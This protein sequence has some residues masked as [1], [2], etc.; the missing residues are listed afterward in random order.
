MPSKLS[1]IIPALNEEK[2]LPLL[3]KCL[4]RERFLIKE[5]IVADAGSIDKTISIAKSFNCRVVEGGLPSVGRNNGAKNA[6][7]DLFLFLD[8]DITLSE[9]FLFNALS[10]FQEKNLDIAS[11]PI[12]PQKNNIFFNRFTFNFFYNWPQRY[13]RKIFPLGAMGIL[14]KK[15]IFEKIKGFDPD[16]RLSEDH[17]FVQSASKIGK[18]API[19]SA[20]IYM[21]QRRFKKDGYFLTILKY[22]LC[23]FHMVI[24]GPV[25]TDI[26][27][28][29]FNH[30]Q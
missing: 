13:L 23:G 12:Y 18:F 14:V 6:E 20:E 17:C 16:I 15:E 24:L 3:L 27:K 26:F 4:Q 19:K 9:R 30:Y 11:F 2:Y 22:L 8:A 1:I 5:I 7:G 10:E 21:S 28:Y 29:K 25:K